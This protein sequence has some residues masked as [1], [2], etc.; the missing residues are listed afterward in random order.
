MS[1]DPFCEPGLVIPPRLPRRGDHLW[2]LEKGARRLT[3]ELR[4]H[5]ESYYFGSV[6]GPTYPNRLYLCGGTS[7][8]TPRPA[9]CR[10]QPTASCYLCALLIYRERSRINARR[11]P[12]HVLSCPLGILALESPDRAVQGVLLRARPAVAVPS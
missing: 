6:L 2:T 8:G 10:A 4:F 11:T 1:D 9:W 3:G 7:G 5:G 12:A